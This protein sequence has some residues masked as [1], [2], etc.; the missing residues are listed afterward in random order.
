MASA[1]HRQNMLNAGYDTVGVGVACSGGQAW[2]VE[3][4]GFVYGNL[5]PRWA[6]RPPRT[7]WRATRS[8]PDRRWP[9]PDRGTRLLPGPGRGAERGGHRRPAASTP[10]PIR[11]PRCPGEPLPH[12]RPPT[13]PFVGIAASAGGAGYWVAEADGT[14]SAHG[15]RRVL[16]LDGRR[17]P[18]P[19][20]SPT[21]WPPRT[22]G[23]T[24]W[25]RPTAASSPSATPASTARWAA[26]RSTPRWSDMAPT[27]DGRGYWLVAADGG[28]FAFGDAALPR[29]DGRPAAQRPGRRHG[30]PTRPALATGWSAADGG[31]FAFGDAGFYG[32]T[33]SLALNAPVVGMAADA[34][35]TGYW[36]VGLGRRHLRLRRRA[37]SAAAPGALRSRPR[38]S[39]WR[40]TRR[41]DGYWLVGQ[42]RRRVRL[43]RAVLR[44]GL[45]GPPVFRRLLRT[46]DGQP[47]QMIDWS[48]E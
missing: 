3:L 35:G 32:S 9:A 1:G 14:V 10:I 29:L 42:R 46:P 5:G 41:P 44:R 15:T 45:T 19:P 36:L 7:R 2:T 24:G 18:W 33:G 43:R 39:A 47:D 17:R 40:P 11:C 22:A 6:A 48:S 16:R 8:R 21:S 12:R 30:R 26:C 37:A 34:A 25:W 13:D 31:I 38:W 23:A 28:I 4:F 20:R 27:P